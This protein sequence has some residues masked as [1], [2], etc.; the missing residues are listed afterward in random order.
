M[1]WN[2]LSFALVPVDRSTFLS[3][4]IAGSLGTPVQRIP[5]SSW[6]VQL[7]LEACSGGCYCVRLCVKGQPT[8][9]GLLPPFLTPSSS[10]PSRVYRAAVDTGS[11]Y[12][13]LGGARDI[14]DNNVG[15]DF[16][17][18]ESGYPPTEEIYG[19]QS[20]FIQWKQAELIVRSHPRL[21]SNNTV[22]GLLDSRLEN[23]AGGTLLGLI[24]HPN[25]PRQLEYYRPTWLQQLFVNDIPVRSF[26]IDQK[27]LTLSSKSLL[28]SS[29]SRAFPLVDIRPLGDFVEH[30]VVRVHELVLNG[31]VRITPEDLGGRPIVAVLDTGLTGC[32][33]IQE[34]WDAL[35]DQA[36]IDPRRIRALNVRVQDTTRSDVI[37][38]QSGRA[39][40]D[41]FYVAPISLDWFMVDNPPLLVVLGQTFLSQGI[42]TIDTEDRLASFELSTDP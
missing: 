20:G 39:F 14:L 7:P 36:S 3:S 25:P 23:E 19:S 5:P 26:S 30:Y 31:R 35:I 32:L 40:N 2:I 28:A 10:R 29:S 42:L 4:L 13:V 33:L 17:L 15:P 34:L 9:T 11:P 24:K 37:D 22:L 18:A 27:H 16:L 1:G 6:T 41:L 21:S 12:L 8:S 38:I